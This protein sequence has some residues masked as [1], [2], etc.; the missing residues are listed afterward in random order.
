MP[1]HIANRADLQLAQL[2]SYDGSNTW[3]S[4]NW[5][6]RAQDQRGCGRLRRPARA[7]RGRI[8][9]D[10]PKLWR[11]FN[12]QRGNR[13]HP[14]SRL[15]KDALSSL[16]ILAKVRLKNASYFVNYRHGLHG[17][18]ARHQSADSG[19][20]ARVIAT[21]APGSPFS[22]H[23]LEDGFNQVGFDRGRMMG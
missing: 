10:W 13:L 12:E 16:T 19:D 8:A 11:I 2:V 15:A 21:G 3:Q 1:E 20:D 6:V 7:K 4:C 18:C 22:A 14:L 9:T 23:E 17:W 5:V